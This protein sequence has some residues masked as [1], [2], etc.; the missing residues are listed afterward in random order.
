M[1]DHP[2]LYTSLRSPYSWFAHVRLLNA[3][4]ALDELEIIP[5]FPPNPE[6]AAAMSSGKTKSAYQ[7]ADIRRIAKGYGLPLGREIPPDPDWWGPHAVFL[8]AR[9]QGRGIEF[10]SHAF[11]ARFA[12]QRDLGDAEVIGELAQDCGLERDAAIAAL[13]DSG[14]RERLAAGFQQMRADHSFGVPTF[15]LGQELFWGNDRLEWFLRAWHKAQG[16]PVPDL[17]ADPLAR[18]F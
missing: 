5:V 2:R 1:S 8:W 9:D 17:R 13:Q 15:V 12:E 10:L 14:L 6:V 7:Q 18:P 3:D 4:F 16:H 11:T